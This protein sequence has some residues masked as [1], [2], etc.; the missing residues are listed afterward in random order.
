MHKI[1]HIFLI[2]NKNVPYLKHVQQKLSRFCYC[3]LPTCA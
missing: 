2:E 3:V 1:K